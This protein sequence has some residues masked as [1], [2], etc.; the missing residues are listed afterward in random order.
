M[1]LF[2]TEWTVGVPANVIDGTRQPTGESQSASI[3]L[4][5]A[6]LTK[7]LTGMIGSQLFGPNDHSLSAMVIPLPTAGNRQFECP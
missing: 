4:Y 6:G 7:L 1:H 2:H 3:A 5:G